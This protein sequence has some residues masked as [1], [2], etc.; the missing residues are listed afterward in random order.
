MAVQKRPTELVDMAKLMSFQGAEPLV[1]HQISGPGCPRKIRLLPLEEL[2][3]GR[4]DDCQVILDEDPVSRRHARVLFAD[5]KPQVLDLGSTN[6]TFLNGKQV[7]RAL[8]K[9]GDQIQIGGSIFRVAMGKE[10]AEPLSEASVKH[11]QTLIQRN[12]GQSSAH[13]GQSSAISGN[14]SEIRLPSLLQVLES[15]R[16]TGTLVVRQAG[17]EGKL[18]IHQGAICHATL[19]RA[20]GVKAVYRLMVLEEGRF[21]FFIPGRSPEYETV[22]G[23]LQKH[24]L[25]AMR[26][27]DEFTVYRKRLP[28]G[29]VRLVLSTD[30]TINPGRVPPVVYEVMAAIGY[31]KTLDRILEFCQL[32]DFEIC[33]ILLALLKHKL[34]TLEPA[35][36]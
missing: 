19:G 16:A 12:K 34:I 3:F 2:V 6:G 36:K 17:Q 22:E 5:L 8:L 14:L 15:D 7:H 29:E 31:Y 23:D 33:R 13:P 21:E 26:Q 4:D 27:K 10:G 18:H 20:R 30:M 32:P 24:L 25:E 28:R 1:L 11:V 35:A 9:D